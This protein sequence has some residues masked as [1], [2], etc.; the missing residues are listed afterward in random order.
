MYNLYPLCSLVEDG[1]RICEEFQ[2]SHIL[3]AKWSLNT[4]LQLG[5]G[6]P[7]YNRCANAFFS[8]LRC[9]SMRDLRPPVPKALPTYVQKAFSI[10]IFPRLPTCT[11]HC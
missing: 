9:L 5:L 4:K 3:N 11:E 7:S 1:L 8:L 6:Y 10:F 2:P